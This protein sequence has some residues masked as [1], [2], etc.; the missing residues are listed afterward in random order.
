MPLPQTAAKALV[1]VVLSLL[2]CSLIT[3]LAWANDV[4]GGV[5]T[6]P[7]PAPQVTAAAAVLMDRLTGEVV[8]S[9]NPD[10]RQAPAS[11]T[12]ILTALVALQKGH[13]DD[14][15]T[16]G[17]NPPRVEGTR[18]YLVEGE[19]ATLEHLLYGMLLNSGNDAALAI[20]EHYGGSMAG[21]AE[22]MNQEAASLGAFNSHFVTPNGLSDPNHYTTARDLAIIARAAMQNPLLARIVSTKTYPWR[23]QAW[24]TTL[25]NQNRLLGRYPG[26]DGV[27]NGYTSEAH[28]TLVESATRQEQSFIAVVLNEPTSSAAEKD[29][30]SLLDYGFKNFRSYRLIRKGEVVKVMTPAAGNKVELVAADD[31]NLLCPN[32][33]PPPRRQLR[34][35]P[36][37]R[38]AAAGTVMGE[39]LFWQD[40]KI[41]GRVNVVN[42]QPLPG[43][44]NSLAGNWWRLGLVFLVL[45]TCKSLV[46]RLRPRF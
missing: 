8:F 34:I 12:K 5:A 40:G 16:V 37:T 29:V 14:V 11:T 2:L 31:L 25:V 17:P 32:T 19:K 4:A 45:F 46:E 26:A 10:A 27:K 39:M 23:G 22:M 35:S 41:V 38:S 30:A 36:I 1:V 24:Q 18:V 13:L 20:A 33:S 15:I 43:Q 28:F 3:P 7:A 9:K 6:S 21:F 42:R 44:P